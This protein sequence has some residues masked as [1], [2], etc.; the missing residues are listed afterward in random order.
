MSSSESMPAVPT[1]LNRWTRVAFVCGLLCVLALQLGHVA[2]VTSATWDEP[3]HLFDG[4]TIW[5]LDDYTLNPEVPPLVKL[6]AALPLLHMHL[7]VPANR[8]R[9]VPEEAFLDGRAFVFGNGGDRVLFPAR[10]ACAL[11]M[12]GLALLTYI[13]AGEMFGLGAGLFA[14]ALL[15]FDPNFLAHGALVTTDIGS[16]C[17]FLAV[18][19]TF[20]RYCK[21]PSWLRLLLVGIAAGLLLAVKFSGIFL[22]PMLFLGALLEWSLA[23]NA[24]IFWRRLAALAAVGVIAWI[25]LWSFYGFRYKAAPE[26]RELNPSLNAYLAKM[27]DQRA[28]RGLGFIARHRILPEAYIWG[29]ENTKNTEFEDNSYFWGRVYRHGNRA[30]FPVA[31]LV[32]STLPFLILLCLSPFAWRWGLKKKSRE[33][34]F[35]LIPVVVYLTISMNSDMDIGMRHLL[36]IYP[37]LY[38]LIAGVAVTLINRNPRWSIAL[39][40]LLCWQIV[41]SYRVAPAYMAYGNE[42]WGG[43]SQVHRYLSDAN[44]DWAQQLKAVKTYLDEQHISNCWFVYFADGAIEPSDYGIPCKRLPTTVSLWWLDLP[45]QVPPVIDGT[46]LISDSDLEGIEFGDGPLNPY[47]R[48]RSIKPTT[49][50]QHGINVYTGRFPVPLAS[51]LVEAHE[52]QKLISA[53]KLKEGLQKASDAAQLAPESAQVQAALGDALVA[54]GNPT[55][56][57]AHYR[58]ALQAA[59]TI[60]PDLQEG[61]A[62]ALK[63]KIDKLNAQQPQP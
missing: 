30:Y 18:M 23:R 44:T 10:M 50:I 28:A 36:P 61:I 20:Y 32:K 35:L 6:T 46:V 37:F 7:A 27:Y 2:R 38:I 60:R 14:L 9:S 58:S 21:K 40:A 19:Y 48:F 42:A 41:T 13:V 33:L 45:M 56:G 15:V 17:G 55:D 1:L 4:Y 52:S 26:G 59:Q 57:L 49:A 22:F 43:P 31:F 53:G 63:L 62:A 29:L 12:L 5:K 39:A 8:G 34:G 24:R 16:A 25:V 54:A 47:D 51:A 11:F 3:H